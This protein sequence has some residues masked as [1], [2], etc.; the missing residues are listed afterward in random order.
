MYWK[1]DV[2]DRTVPLALCVQSLK[3]ETSRI[4]HRGIRFQQRVSVVTGETS[5]G[6]KFGM[7]KEMECGASRKVH[8]PA[9]KNQGSPRLPMPITKLMANATRQLRITISHCDLVMTGSRTLVRGANTVRSLFHSQP[10]TA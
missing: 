2:R 3:A 6:F 9:E 7:K 4:S 10:L 5:F 8:G 1:W